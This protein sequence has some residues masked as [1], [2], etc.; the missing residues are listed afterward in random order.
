MASK[1]AFANSII[2]KHDLKLVLKMYNSFCHIERYDNLIARER[3]STFGCFFMVC[4]AST[5]SFVLVVSASARIDIYDIKE[6]LF[7]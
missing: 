1:S 5:S 7:I 2:I 3:L 4:K 6:L